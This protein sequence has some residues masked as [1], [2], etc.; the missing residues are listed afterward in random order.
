MMKQAN[1]TNQPN[2]QESANT[3]QWV[4]IPLAKAL[5]LKKTEKFILFKVGDGS[6]IVSAK[7]KR[8][9]ESDTHIFLSVPKT[10]EFTIKYNSYDQDA[11]KWVTTR[12][13]IAKAE[14]V[15]ELVDL[16]PEDLPF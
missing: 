12:E 4:F 15:K 9:K 5:I 2:A 8:A 14:Q 1:Q 3:T 16:D 10:Y 13:R 7:F 6:A 11:K